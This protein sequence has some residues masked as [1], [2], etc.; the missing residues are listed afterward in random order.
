MFRQSSSRAVP[1]EDRS[2]IP[3]NLFWLFPRRQK[4]VRFFFNTAVRP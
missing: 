1:A 3:A 4:Q 2:R